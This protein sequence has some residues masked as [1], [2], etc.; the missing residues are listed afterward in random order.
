M[1]GHGVAR[2]PASTVRAR[3]TAYDYDAAIPLV[4]GRRV[5]IVTLVCCL[6]HCGRRVLEGKEGCH[7]VG[8]EAMLQIC[9]C[10]G[11]DG[12]WA[13][14]ARRADPDVKAAPGIECF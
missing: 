10:R 8:F 12:R 2:A 5:R 14:E 7:G 3:R 13:E 1:A 4:L 9:R 11:V 6:G